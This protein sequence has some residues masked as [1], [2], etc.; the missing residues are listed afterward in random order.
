LRL[1]SRKDT[2][3]FVSVTE[4]KLK[5]V[6]DTTKSVTLLVAC[7]SPFQMPVRVVFMVRRFTSVSVTPPIRTHSLSYQRRS[8]NLITDSV[9]KQ[10]D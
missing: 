4:A 5:I 10:H 6:G 1:R 3:P 9:V 8:I 7:L 2:I